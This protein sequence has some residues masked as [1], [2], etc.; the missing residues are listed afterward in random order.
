MKVASTVLRGLGGSNA[1]RLPDH[2]IGLIGALFNVSTR[3][4]VSF[5]AKMLT[6]HPPSALCGPLGAV[7]RLN[8][9]RNMGYP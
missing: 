3:I 7:S 4:P 1:P 8:V 5:V 2:P 9:C 6:P